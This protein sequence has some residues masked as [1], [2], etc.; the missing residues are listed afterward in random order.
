MGRIGEKMELIKEENTQKGLNIQLGVI[1]EES[2]SSLTQG[3]F[4]IGTESSKFKPR[5]GK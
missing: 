3:H 1:L 4:G 2:A 5:H